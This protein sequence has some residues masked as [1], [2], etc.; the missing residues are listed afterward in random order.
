MSLF[1]RSK[2]AVLRSIFAGAVVIAALS[3]PG[4][5][6][7]AQ[8][9]VGGVYIDPDGMLRQ[10]STLSEQDLRERL[11][12]EG[13]AVPAQFS[14]A[15]SP[16]RKIS[17]R[18][19]EQAVAALHESGQPVPADV[20]YLAGLTGIRCVLVFP[21]A[22]DVVIA[23][24]AEGWQQIPAGDVVGQQSQRPVLQLDDLIV[25][26]RYA[27]ADRD[28]DSFLG[29]SIE[30]TEKGVQAHGAFMRG[31]GEMNAS[32]LPEVL[33]GLEQAVGPQDV[34]VYGVN[35]ATRFALQMIA[36]DYRLKRIALAHEPSPSAKLPSYLDLAEKSIAG[37]KPRQHRWWFVGHYDAIR[38]T[39]DN[40][41]FE[42]EG[43][44]LK[45]DTA[46]VHAGD[47]QQRD[48]SKPAKSAK[49]FADLATKHLPEMARKI[50]A[51]AELQNLVS[52]AVAGTLVR[53]Q[54]VDADRDGAGAAGPD[55]V[56]ASGASRRW[57]PR[58]FLDAEHCP[59]ATYITPRQTPSLA[60]ARFVRNQI[61][62]FSVCGGV[63]IDPARLADSDRLKPAAGN[64][65]S[66]VRRQAAPPADA[67]RWWWD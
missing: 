62:M 66:D 13:G 61:W 40:L 19:L 55:A 60:N 12:R 17:L 27:F 51:V 36:A 67:D 48:T 16:L 42:F 1:D 9:V 2:F 7:M 25:A 45:V 35:P 5:E 47:P 22:E 65:L 54:S 34:H 56:A 18:R 64:K 14:A 10:T 32:R 44:G 6:A 29:C 33:Q 63:E 30:P 46:P 23:G 37:S 58:H 21:E 8:G 20:R 11:A 41:A 15:A 24:P 28:E 57:R 26:L 50:P 3:V 43:Q 31:I 59:V 38:R 39:A 4:G 52:L 53:R 49:Q